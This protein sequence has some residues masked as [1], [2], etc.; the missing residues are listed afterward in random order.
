VTLHCGG[1]ACFLPSFPSIGTFHP[2][3]TP[4]FQ[5]Q[6]IVCVF[7]VAWKLAQPKPMA[8]SSVAEELAAWSI[9]TAAKQQVE[10]E[11]E[12]ELAEEGD[13]DDEEDEALNPEDAFES[14]Q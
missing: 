10:L 3:N 6:F 2:S 9:I 1:I 5:K 8:L 12:G 11:L 4:L 7:T 14:E 13:L